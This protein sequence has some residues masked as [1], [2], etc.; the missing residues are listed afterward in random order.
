A[1]MEDL[2]RLAQMEAKTNQFNVSTRRLSADA[3]G[4]MMA[5]EGTFVY[6]VSLKDRFTDHGLVA[7]LSASIR[8]GALEVSDWLMSCRVFAR[9]LEHYVVEKLRDIAR[10]AGVSTI[11]VRF[12]KTDKNGVLIDRFAS[13]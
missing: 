9:T 5:A 4:A 6:C 8:D 3:L 1:K 11:V 12:T 10:R 7:Y 13:L 2:V